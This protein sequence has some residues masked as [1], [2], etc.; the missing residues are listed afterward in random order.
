MA[1]AALIV[2]AGDGIS[3]SFARVLAREGFKV[4]LAARD[5]D[6]L[7]ALTDE[8][9]GLAL[10]CD[11]DGGGRRS[12]GCSPR[13]TSSS[14]RS[15][16][17][18][19]TRAS[20]P[21]VLWSISTLPKCGRPSWSPRSA[22]FWWHSR[23]RGACSARAAARSCSPARR[24]A[25]RATRVGLVRDGQVRAARPRPEHGARARPAEHP[26]RPFRDRRRGAQRAPPGV[27]RPA[28]QH[29]RSGRHR[30][31]PTSPSSSSRAAPGPG[32]S[33]SAPGSR[34]SEARSPGRNIQLPGTVDGRQ[35]LRARRAGPALRACLQHGFHP[36]ARGCARNFPGLAVLFARGRVSRGR[37]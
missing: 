31:R 14:A 18:T 7:A 35:R 5:T 28:R 22:A 1:K 30:R 29:A 27:R 16:S 36:R 25:S 10:R 6:K 9:G 19:T 24:P 4:G 15:T 23:R 34:R 2:G 11:V 33:S 8:I 12:S 37:T 17:C 20:A 26:C 3:A 32:R 13:S 21:T